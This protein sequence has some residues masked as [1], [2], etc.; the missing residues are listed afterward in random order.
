MLAGSTFEG[1]MSRV[2]P[3][4]T[5]TPPLETA[6]EVQAF[7]EHLGFQM[8]DGQGGIALCL[9]QGLWNDEQPAEATHAERRL[10]DHYDDT[11]ILAWNGNASR[12]V[13]TAEPGA[14]YQ[15]VAPH[16]SG[17]PRLTWG[18]HH[19]TLGTHR[20]RRGLVSATGRD[21]VWRDV[22]GDDLPGA[23]DAI[24][25]G[26]FGIHMHSGGLGPNIGRWSAGCVV[27]W[28]G[29][30][31]PW[32]DFYDRAASLITGSGPLPVV[33]WPSADFDAFRRAGV[34]MR[35][36]LALGCLGPWVRTL[37]R[38]LGGLVI[39]GDFGPKT[40]RAVRAFRRSAGLPAGDLWT[41]LCWVAA[42][43]SQD[44]F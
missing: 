24:S 14:F 42:D 13:V 30:E 15:D 10:P 19:Y 7:C 18:L 35:P 40:A 26:P 4:N 22:D 12:Y 1:N 37:Q 38:T 6:V 28:G 3:R 41:P 5:P 31:G 43:R 44:Q 32:S 36:R 17:P 34:A 39:D 29:E 11:L 2:L 9:V 33:V 8:I 16:P 21:R 23:N 25:V 20:N 27:F